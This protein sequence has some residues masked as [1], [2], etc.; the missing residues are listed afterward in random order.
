M[1]F[2]ISRFIYKFFFIDGVRYISGFEGDKVVPGIS[3]FADN[4]QGVAG[5]L[6]PVLLKALE[7]IPSNHHN[8]TNVYVK[9][10]AGNAY[11]LSLPYFALIHENHLLNIIN[12]L[13]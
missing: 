10:T 9:A 7:S 2:I 5:Y 6:A 4:H 13:H 11:H 3:S 1:L 8:I 12:S